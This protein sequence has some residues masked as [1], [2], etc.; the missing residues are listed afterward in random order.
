MMLYLLFFIMLWAP[1][2]E[3]I[4]VFCC[5]T[6]DIVSLQEVR[7]GLFDVMSSY[8]L[9]KYYIMQKKITLSPFHGCLIVICTR[10]ILI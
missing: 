5:P 10:V 8:G 1:K 3:P 6:V 9:W 7:P 2:K 4:R